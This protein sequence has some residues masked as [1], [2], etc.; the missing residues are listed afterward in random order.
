MKHEI[1]PRVTSF[2]KLDQFS[3]FFGRFSWKLVQDRFSWCWIIW[4]YRFSMVAFNFSHI[5]YYFDM[6]AMWKIIE[7]LQKL[8]VEAKTCENLGK[9]LQDSL[10]SE[11][12][13]YSKKKFFWKS[14]IF[15]RFPAKTKR[16]F[17][18]WLTLYIGRLSF[19]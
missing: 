8:C 1:F 15:K 17:F 16:V 4:S 12:L 9:V 19:F 14:V 7:L 3:S 11:L 18:F 6:L 5:T 13:P 10:T 2:Y